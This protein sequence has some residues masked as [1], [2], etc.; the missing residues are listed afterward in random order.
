MKKDEKEGKRRKK[1]EKGGKRRKKEEKEG[2]TL[3]VLF[4]G[5]G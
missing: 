1:D 3:M 5:L 4:L 2:R